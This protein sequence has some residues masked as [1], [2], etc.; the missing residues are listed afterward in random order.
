MGVTIDNQLNWMHTLGAF[1]W[2]N[3]FKLTEL[4]SNSTRIVVFVN[5][6]PEGIT[7][8]VKKKMAASHR[9]AS[10]KR[11]NAV[12]LALLQELVYSSDEIEKIRI[13]KTKNKK[14]LK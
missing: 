5:F 13:G 11:E 3:Q 7:I 12:M 8:C 2:Y 1:V 4:K 14:C 10:R 6:G 9:M